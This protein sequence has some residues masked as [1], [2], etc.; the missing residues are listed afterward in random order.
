MNLLTVLMLL[1]GAAVGV[2][3]GRWSARSGARA[4]MRRQLARAG[5]QMRREVAHRPVAA[6]RATSETAR[7]A[8]EAE[9]YKAGQKHG[10]EDVISI[11]PLLVATQQRPA[12][13]PGADGDE[14][15]AAADGNDSI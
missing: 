10:R 3:M 13:G 14:L 6:A 11:M 2:V 4:V 8:R 15:P 7:V 1:M 5:G 12:E 9:A